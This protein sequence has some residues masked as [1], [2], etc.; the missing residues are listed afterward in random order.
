MTSAL[1]QIGGRSKAHVHD[2]ERTQRIERWRSDPS[3]RPMTAQIYLENRCHLK[4]AHCYEDETSHPHIEGMNLE[5]YDRLFVQLK[6]LGVLGVTFTGGEIFLRR[7]CLD[8]VELA[9]KHRFAVS[10]YTSGT[11]IDEAKA[12]RIRDLLVSDVHISVYSHD[13]AVHDQFT[14]VPRSWERSVRALKWLH[15]AG[16]PTILRSNIMTFN[17]DHIDEL[18]DLAKSVGADYQF[19]PS[20]KPKLNGDRSPLRFAVSADKIRLRVLSRPD[21]FAAFRNNE[22]G[23][24]CTGDKSFLD[25]DSV[26][27]GAARGLISV[28]ADGAIHACGFF[29]TSAGNA[30]QEP[31]EDIWFGARQLDDIRNTTKGDMQ[32]CTSCDVKS[33][34]SPCMAYSAAEHDGDHRQCASSSRQIATA[35]RSLAENRVRRH[36]Q[37]ERGRALPIV[38]DASVPRPATKGLPPLSTE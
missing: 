30:L 4:C 22:P 8:V 19:D 35:V 37:M 21:L 29:P 15:A 3:V 5:Q 20:V 7:D 1:L 36:Q 25:D 9:R 18:I 24:Y 33:T 27:C 17:V 11:L 23:S 34:C 28:A 2:A 6:Q 16:V 14:G 31:L 10:L 12:Q 26:M 38:G 32:A 13:A